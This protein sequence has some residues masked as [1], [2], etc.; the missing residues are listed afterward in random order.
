MEE[1]GKSLNSLKANCLH[2]K[3]QEGE[4]KMPDYPYSILIKTI[5]TQL[6]TKV[7]VI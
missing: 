1:L 3:K 5:K 7:A 4:K 6:S 2:I